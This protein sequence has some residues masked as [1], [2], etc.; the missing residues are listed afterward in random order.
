MIDKKEIRE[1]IISG[2][3]QI[4][5]EMKD[6]LE[7]QIHDD[8]VLIGPRGILDS[9]GLVNLI[10]LTEQKFEEEFER[11]ITI[12]DEQTLSQNDNP[13]RTVRSLVDHISL[14]LKKHILQ[15]F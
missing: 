6:S 5:E 9:L 15:I 8:T 12:A 7:S 1:I 14:L 2:L 10:V 13:F 4:K 3:Y 11:I